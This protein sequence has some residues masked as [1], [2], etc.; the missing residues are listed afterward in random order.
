MPDLPKY[1]LEKL[2]EIVLMGEWLQEIGFN[3]GD[4]LILFATNNGIAI[5]PA[6]P[7]QEQTPG[8]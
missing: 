4:E 8:P 6:R 5:V 7:A 3:E 1:K 2:L